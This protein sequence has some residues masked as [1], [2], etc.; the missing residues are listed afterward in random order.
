MS[1]GAMNDCQKTIPGSCRYSSIAPLR[2]IVKSALCA[3]L[4]L[5]LSG[6]LFNSV[7]EVKQQFCDFDAHFSIQTQGTTDFIMQTPVLRDSDIL[8]LSPSPPT[9]VSTDGP[10]KQM[11]FVIEKL[12]VNA[13]SAVN[14]EIRLYFERL[15]GRFKLKRMQLDEN[16]AGSLGPY[17]FDSDIMVSAYRD[18]CEMG[19][20][21]SSTRIIRDISAEEIEFLPS[22]DEMLEQFGAP[23]EI[24]ETNRVFAYEYR[25]KPDSFE[26]GKRASETARIVVW[27]DDSGDKPLRM[28]FSY[29]RYQ[30]EADFIA[31]K[32][33]LNVSL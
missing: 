31:G 7:I 25:V 11:T 27:F 23:T 1:P 14:P 13:E 9:S 6:C 19:V 16:L 5:A 32:M 10:L 33:K 12:G 4:L 15:D 21:Q 18:I 28:K 3:G 2:W 22:R 30:T 29:S 24:I 8:W 17:R 26:A 20:S